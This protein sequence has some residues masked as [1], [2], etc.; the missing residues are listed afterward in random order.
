VLAA[1]IYCAVLRI[2]L[3]SIL[4]ELAAAGSTCSYCTLPCR[5][6]VRGQNHCGVRLC[7]LKAKCRL[8]VLILVSSWAKCCRSLLRNQAAR[9]SC[10]ACA[11]IVGQAVK[12]TLA[13]LCCIERS[14]GAFG[15]V[16]C[17]GVGVLQAKLQITAA[18]ENRPCLTFHACSL[19]VV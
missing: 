6:S 19:S 7:E 5:V 1:Y 12:C 3:A 11:C 14:W 4:R 8:W 9:R 16:C 18:S 10:F 17:G 2:L 15:G 13:Y